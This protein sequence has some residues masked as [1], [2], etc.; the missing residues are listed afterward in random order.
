M[1]TRLARTAQPDSA[2]DRDTA[3]RA[4]AA[5]NTAGL[6]RIAEFA[7]VFAAAQLGRIAAAAR[8]ARA[9]AA[10]SIDGAELAEALRVAQP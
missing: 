8:N 9:S 3:E 5:S 6:V 1:G 2:A 10:G 4:C 7:G